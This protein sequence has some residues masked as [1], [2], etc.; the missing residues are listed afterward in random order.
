MS[1]L[2]I[3]KN[4]KLQTLKSNLN[5][6][7]WALGKIIIINYLLVGRAKINLCS[8]AYQAGHNE[9]GWKALDKNGSCFACTEKKKTQLSTEK[10]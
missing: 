4:G 2:C 5:E 7:T 9:A 6:K 3:L 8:T 1:N 10:N